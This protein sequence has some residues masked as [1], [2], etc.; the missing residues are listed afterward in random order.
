MR[1]SATEAEPEFWTEITGSD[2]DGFDLFAKNS[3]EQE[4]SCTVKVTVTL[5]DGSTK[6]YEYSRT[7]RKTDKMSFGGEAGL[8]PAP[9]K[10]VEIS[11]KSCS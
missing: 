5:G 10:S 6:S 8:K 2:K 4:K 11:S 3:D 9:I 1:T 7:V